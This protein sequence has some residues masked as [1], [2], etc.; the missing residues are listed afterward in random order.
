MKED[1]SKKFLELLGSVT[2][3]RAKIAIN[4][5]LKYGFITTEVLKNEYGY[6]HPPR[7][8]RDIKEHGIPVDK[9]TVD[10]S[11]GKK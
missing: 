8:I 3:K 9:F 7:A 1:Y 5:I 6:N 2:S 10:S 11:D 4:H